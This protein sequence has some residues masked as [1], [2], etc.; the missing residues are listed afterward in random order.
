M[1]HIVV[2]KK[3]CKVILLWKPE[4]TLAKPQKE[5]K[6][7]PQGYL[8]VST[9]LNDEGLPVANAKVYIRSSG[10]TSSQDGQF[11]SS[12]D[13]SD[14]FFNYVLTTNSSGLTDR[15][16]IETPS[17]QGSLNEQ[18]TDVPYTVADVYV[19]ADGY[20][21]TRI[22]RVQIFSGTDSLLP[23]VLIPISADYAQSQNGTIN[24]NIPPSQLLFPSPRTQSGPTEIQAAAMITSDIFIP[25]TIRVHL[26]TPSSNAENVSVPF[27]EYIKN[28]TS[29]EIYPTWPENS[30]RSN[31][32]AI[33]SLALNRF[34]TEWYPSQGYNF[35]ITNSTQ[36]DQAFVPGRNIFDNISRIVDEIFNSYV[37]REGY[38]NPLFTQFCDGRQSQCQGLSQWGTVTLAENGYTP[39]QILRQYYGQDVNI[40][41][42]TDIRNVESSYPGTPLS[43]GDSGPDVLTIQQQLMRIRENYPA[44]PLIPSIDGNFGSSTDQAVRTFQR[45][46]DLDVDGIVGKA[47][48]YRISYVYSSVK[49][50]AEVTGEGETDIFSGR[51]PTSTISRGDSGDEV[52]LLQRIINYLAIFYPSIPSVAED[53]VF[54]QRTEDAIRQFQATFG[55]EQTGV[56]TPQIWEYLYDVNIYILRTIT[57]ILPRQGYPGQPLRRGDENQDVR[58]MQE[59]LSVISTRYPS[60][61]QI[62]PDGIF[63]G[64][65]ELAVLRFQEATGLNSTGV[66]DV[67]TWDRIVEVYNFIT[68]QSMD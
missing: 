50:L 47:T 9:R 62:E 48:W 11:T 17:A 45:I 21:P 12:A 29:S 46:F 2:H 33:I 25:E 59:Y 57:P 26:G 55:L 66:I 1:S 38:I 14:T 52:L 40:N 27:V 67:S 6:I 34:F 32:Y 30:I 13:V 18:S 8:T 24:Y 5:V 22:R 3:V 49:K 41:T 7:L 68:S 54:G 23:V 44:I 37:V 19:Q 58:L 61:P 56:V 43:I 51:V 15:V 4:Y 64:D 28:V 16:E 35:D 53:S 36:F 63:G 60:V 65:T 10:F 31:I 42:T 20:Y 39:L